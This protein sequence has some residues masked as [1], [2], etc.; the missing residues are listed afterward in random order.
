MVS[1]MMGVVLLMMV[2]LSK[3]TLSLLLPLPLLYLLLMS[4]LINQLL[5]MV[6]PELPELRI[7]K[8]DIVRGIHEDVSRMSDF[9]QIPFVGV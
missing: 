6:N 7:L 5:L 2:F 3:L 8:R 1:V 4:E 9:D